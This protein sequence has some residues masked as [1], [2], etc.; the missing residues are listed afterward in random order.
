MDDTRSGSEAG[1]DPVRALEEMDP[2]EAVEAA[3]QHAADLAAR[4]EGVVGQPGEPK[5]S[6]EDTAGTGEAGEG[7]G[8]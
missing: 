1:A 3:E 7:P 2:A 6:V 5:R 8:T 4:L